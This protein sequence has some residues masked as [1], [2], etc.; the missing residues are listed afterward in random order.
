MKKQ[1]PQNDFQTIPALTATEEHGK[2]FYALIDNASD[3]II[4][5]D[6]ET[7]LIVSANRQAENLLGIPLQ[8]LLGM[9]QSRIHP[10]GEYTLYRDVYDECAQKGYVSFDDLSLL[11]SDGERLPVEGSISLTELNEKKYVQSIFRDI[12]ERRNAEKALM[13]SEEK[14]SSLFHYS[15][16]PIFIHDLQGD[17]LD[18]NQ[19]VTDQ[20]E[21]ARIDV[22]PLNIFEIQSVESADTSR[23][24][25]AKI[26]EKGSI[27][28]EATFKKKTGETFSA[29]VSASLFQVGTMRIVQSVVRD[30]SERKKA[31]EE[32][33]HYRIQLEEAVRARTEQLV[34]ANKKLQKEITVRRNAEKRLVEYHKQLQSLASQLSLIEEREKR[35]IATELHDCI[36]QTL[37]LAKIKLGL[38]NKQVASPELKSSA[39]EILNLIEQTIKET[40][41]L[42]FELSPP[43]LYELGFEQ[44]IQWLIDQVHEK[45]GI[46]TTLVSDGSD[47]PFDSNIRFFLFQAVRE[48]MINI[49]KHAQSD[50][51]KIMLNRQNNNRLKITIEDYGRGFS[52]TES[53][54]S[55]FGLFN[56]RER[57][58][59][60]NGK[61]LLSSSPGR[62]TV[63]TLEAPFT[64][65]EQSNRKEPV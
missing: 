26:H 49:A 48:L 16:D 58:N 6:A 60:I 38:L 27:H 55:G 30:I 11:N 8:K 25:Y 24:R 46:Q 4:I 5:S 40:R 65:N 62:G 22:L 1:R 54:T 33:Q 43:I 31:E 3:A 12:T 63:V 20:F 2:V 7:G 44:A 15:N 18:V 36:G 64:L 14:Y 57:M 59:H 13:D 23:A 17:I 53:K 56:I 45:Y 35:R 21:Y 52:D 9:H 32:L 19:K 47:K 28:F 51:A 10:A 61:F 34:K 37:A 50:S 39:R 41:T 29:D 42:T